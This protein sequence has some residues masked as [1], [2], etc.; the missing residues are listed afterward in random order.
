MQ[1]KFNLWDFVII[2]G[3][4]SIDFPSPEI[5]LVDR[6]STTMIWTDNLVIPTI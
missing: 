2:H 6:E 1:V 4:Q 3:L 5:N